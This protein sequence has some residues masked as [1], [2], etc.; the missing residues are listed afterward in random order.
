MLYLI[1]NVGNQLGLDRTVA[2]A[3]QV[4]LHHQVEGEE[5]GAQ[6]QDH[7]KQERHQELGQVHGRQLPQLKNLR[8][9]RDLLRGILEY[10]MEYHTY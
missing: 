2:G 6:K 1:A 10:C 5:E 8:G 4:L 9:K 3:D 7:H